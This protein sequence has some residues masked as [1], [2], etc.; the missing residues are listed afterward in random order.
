[1]FETWN[2]QMQIT[3]SWY[4]PKDFFTMFGNFDGQVWKL[5]LR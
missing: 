1:M 2:K 4:T 3:Y 5:V